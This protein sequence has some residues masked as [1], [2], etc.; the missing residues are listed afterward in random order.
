MKNDQKT[1]AQLAEE[2]EVLR[3]RL[4]ELESKISESESQ[5]GELTSRSPRQ[6]LP[7]DIEFI[8]DFDITE[9]KGVDLSESGVCFEISDHLPFEMQFRHEGHFNR[10]RAHLIWVKQTPEGRYRFGLKFVSPEPYPD[11]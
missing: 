4:A 9:A 6:E 5:K 7:A 11:I 1:N 10:R 2:V 3:R 8:A